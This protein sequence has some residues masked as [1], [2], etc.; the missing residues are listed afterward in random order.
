MGKSDGFYFAFSKQVSRGKD[1]IKHVMENNCLPSNDHILNKVNFPL[2]HLILSKLK[3]RN[4]DPINMG[5]LKYQNK[6]H[7]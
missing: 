1:A 2:S 7:L 3:L 6:N 4:G 5:V